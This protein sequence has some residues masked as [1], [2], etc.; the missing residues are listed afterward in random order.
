MH[1]LFQKVVS[2]P[3]KDPTPGQENYQPPTHL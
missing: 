1:M 2:Y 3:P